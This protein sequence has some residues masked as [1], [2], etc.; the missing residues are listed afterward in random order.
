MTVVDIKKAF[1]TS[2]KNVADF[3]HT[4]GVGYYIPLYQR[5]YSWNV[6]NIEKLVEDICKG[7]NALI[8]MP[9]NEKEKVVRFLGS[10][11]LVSEKDKNAIQPQD[12]TALPAR[13][14]KIIDGQQRISTIALLCCVLYQLIETE[15]RKIV[16]K[17]NDFSDLQEA[18]DYRLQ[19]L[20]KV[21][22]IDLG[23]GQPKIKPKVIRGKDDKWILSGPATNYQSPV[24]AFIAAFIESITNSANE[25][26]ISYPAFP[27]D[28]LV[29]KNL[30]SMKDKL[31]GFIGG[32]TDEDLLP[33]AWKLIEGISEDQLWDYE[34]PDLVSIVQQASQHSN[35]MSKEE[36]VTCRLT[37]LFAF[38]HYLL[39]RCCFT[40]IEPLDE[41]WAFD[42]FQSL[43]ATGTPLT[44]IETFKPAVVNTF[45]RSH[46]GFK[47]SKAEQYFDEVDKLFKPLSSASS[48]DRLTD[49]F[50]TAFAVAYKGEKLPSQ[51]SAQ[52][53][54]L[55]K[56]YEK[57]EDKNSREE[58]V[59]RLSDLAV[60]WSEIIQFDRGGLLA[61]SRILPMKD[62]EDQVA[63]MCLFYLQDASHKMA[64][65]VLSRY[66][67]LVVRQQPKA[68]EEFVKA[69]KAIAAFFT[70]W[71]SALSTSGLD[72]A[73][74]MIMESELSWEKSGISID[75]T[76][77]KAKLREELVKKKVGT[78]ETWKA[79]AMQ[80]LRYENTS[81]SVCRFVLLICSYDT[82]ADTSKSGL[83]M[84]SQSN[85]S[86]EYLRPAA[87]LDKKLKTIEHVAPQSKGNGWDDALY[88]DLNYQRIGNLTLL[89]G[90]I[91]SS[92]GNRPW[93]EKWF[94]FR[95]LI[96]G[97]DAA[98]SELDADQ[99]KYG[100][101]LK[102]ETIDI[103][104]NA[105]YARHVEPIIKLG[106][107]GNWNKLLI[108]ARS[109]RICEILWT[110]MMEWLT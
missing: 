50:L 107:D 55:N 81:I 58:F 82:M 99:S 2:A 104:K 79:R 102:P 93:I 38:S 103:L 32:D 65:S 36:E 46:Q 92:A 5:E 100:L 91:N 26:P 67:A 12:K 86:S 19:E 110:R 106:A 13:I 49:D 108:D 23:R 109:E 4:P 66:Y 97:S 62:A 95:Y 41:E 88:E 14:D 22:S 20:S 45:D 8:D 70:L 69:C 57:C 44:A 16:Q 30:K 72:S 27:K 33:Q 10:V 21:F 29:G 96:A 39:Q 75:S 28:S 83:M 48:K 9:K 76:T 59:R 3:F 87:W 43:N 18:V 89:P 54:K 85:Y 68:A 37:Q 80:Y 74:R 101:K 52:R 60:Y 15:N 6:E 7:V 84:I 77:L 11:I 1:D 51:F 56:W 47:G 53:S 94:Y 31:E 35:S 98:M 64:N 25:K 73:Y 34:R 78:K 71:R 105:H 63:L 90:S 40:V 61:F 42:M 17:D 24:A